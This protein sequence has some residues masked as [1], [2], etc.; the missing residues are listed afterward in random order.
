M[1]LPGVL[2]AERQELVPR[3]LGGFCF[4]SSKVMD[5]PQVTAARSEADSPRAG[6]WPC[7]Q[8]LSLHTRAACDLAS[9]GGEH[10]TSDQS[11]P[12]LPSP[13]LELHPASPLPSLL[14]PVVLSLFFFPFLRLLSHHICGLLLLPI[15]CESVVICV[16]SPCK[17][18]LAALMSG[19]LKNTPTGIH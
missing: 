1:A 4:L 18:W 3:T 17:G 10:G 7:V 8:S 19:L 11:V 2:L 12:T 9:R 15:G 13:E 5:L 16:L 14:I 6:P